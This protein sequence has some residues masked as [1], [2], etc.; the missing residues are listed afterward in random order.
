[1]SFSILKMLSYFHYFYS[2]LLFKHIKHHRISVSVQRFSFF[3][4]IW[5][6]SY[7]EE[8]DDS[9]RLPAII[10]NSHLWLFISVLNKDEYS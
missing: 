3:L 4:E 2:Q 9:K 5:K 10:Y 8:E 7:S 1:M 6:I